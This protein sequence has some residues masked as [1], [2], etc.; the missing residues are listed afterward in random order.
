MKKIYIL[1]NGW[2][3][4]EEQ[5]RQRQRQKSAK[6]TKNRARKMRVE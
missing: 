4:M 3:G 2:N 5:Q 1:K 6:Y